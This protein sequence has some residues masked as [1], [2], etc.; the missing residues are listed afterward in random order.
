MC[1]QSS[2]NVIR[3][4]CAYHCF[5]VLSHN[6]GWHLAKPE[7]S[8]RQRCGFVFTGSGFITY[9]NRVPVVLMRFNHC[10][11][12]WWVFIKLWPLHAS[13]ML[14]YELETLPQLHY[15]RTLL[16]WIKSTRALR[17][18]HYYSGICLNHGCCQK[19]TSFEFPSFSGQMHLKY[20][21]KKKN[22]QTSMKCPWAR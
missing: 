17:H 22:L 14:L 10:S 1:V 12:E 16:A 15:C 3:E 13:T 7:S 9:W 5:L 18:T 11:T 8:I 4:H 2:R 6:L 20:Q 19:L 21:K